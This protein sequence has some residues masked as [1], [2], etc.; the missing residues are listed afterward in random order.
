MM[1]LVETFEAIPPNRRILGAVLLGAWIYVNWDVPQP[2][3][4]LA[5]D[6][7]QQVLIVPRLWTRGDARFTALAQFDIRA[8]VLS[9]NHYT[10]DGQADLSPVDLALGWGRM[11]DSA[12]LNEIKIR[13]GGRFYF[14]RPRFGRTLPIPM[15][16]VIS[17]SANMHMI[18][19]DE[20]V[21]KKLLDTRA[22]QLVSISGFLVQVNRPNG[23]TWRSSLSR[24]DSGPGACEVVW[25]ERVNVQST[26]EERAPAGESEKLNIACGLAAKP[27]NAT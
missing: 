8:R 2:P 16:E 24:T 1:G 11:S 13:Q 10:F 3:G 22:G 20:E 5:P 25:V 17:H 18:P 12:V 6:D 26:V 7:P 15:S 23:W 27:P 21:K 4:V 19:A 14:W 9:T